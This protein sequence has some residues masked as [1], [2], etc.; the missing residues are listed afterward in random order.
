MTVA[1][2]LDGRSARR[3]VNAARDVYY[4]HFS[5]DPHH[6]ARATREAW[7][8]LEAAQGDY[9]RALADAKEEWEASV[10]DRHNDR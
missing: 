3:A 2:G 10:Y 7:E 8:A 1:S 6:K 5:S 4:R 9:L